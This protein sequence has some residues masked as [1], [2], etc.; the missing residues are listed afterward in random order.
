MQVSIEL[1]GHPSKPNGIHITRGAMK[2]GTRKLLKS[3]RFFPGRGATRGSAT[4][5]YPQGYKKCHHFL[6]PRGCHD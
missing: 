6:P 2:P 3:L 1:S 4:A 5:G